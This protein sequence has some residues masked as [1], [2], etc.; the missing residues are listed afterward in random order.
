MARAG[1]GQPKQDNIPAKNDSSQSKTPPK[2][3]NA[4]YLEKLQREREST[5]A[6]EYKNIRRETI[7]HRR[8]TIASHAEFKQQ[9][10]SL[11]TK[12]VEIKQKHQKQH[13]HLLN[14]EFQ[15]REYDRREERSIQLRIQASKTPH[16]GFLNG[17][18]G[19][20]SLTRTINP[21]DGDLDHIK[22][23][24]HG[25]YLDHK[26]KSQMLAP[27]RQLWSHPARNGHWYPAGGSPRPL[28]R[29]PFGALSPLSS[30]P[31]E[32]YEQRLRGLTKGHD[33]TN[34]Y[35]HV[36][37]V[38]SNKEF[39]GEEDD[40]Q[41]VMIISTTSA[42]LDQLPEEDQKAVVQALADIRWRFE[43]IGGRQYADMRAFDERDMSKEEF[44]QQLKKHL[45]L[46][47][48]K[49]VIQLLFNLIDRDQSGYL[50]WTELLP[51]LY[52]N[53]DDT[54]MSKAL[55]TWVPVLTGSQLL[56]DNAK[57]WVPSVVPYG[58]P[59]NERIRGLFTMTHAEYAERIRARG[60]GRAA[61]LLTIE[62]RVRAMDLNTR[63]KL[64]RI[65]ATALSASLSAAP[66]LREKYKATVVIK[67]LKEVEGESVRARIWRKK[68]LAISALR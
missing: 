24:D 42:M 25:E 28:Q 32:D 46:K 38:L 17:P 33:V 52:G 31:D 29:P 53:M 11:I 50:S 1:R 41:E 59:I 16:M 55:G 61:V 63:K 4:E 45:N 67:S 56:A 39:S 8:S 30:F 58:R 22:D 19:K 62:E 68:S 60:I 48:K 2:L 10:K 64:E 26:H 49:K 9:L 65:K 40:H 47:F 51:K 35:S 18:Q 5:V 37:S 21:D 12:S 14:R 13:Q 6:K 7:T 57:T 23:H 20:S 66:V 43:V 36:G 15:A 34:S 27:D 44:R 54:N 3:S